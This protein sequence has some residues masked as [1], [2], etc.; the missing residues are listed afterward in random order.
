MRYLSATATREVPE[1]TEA[2]VTIGD[3]VT[4]TDPD[5][6]NTLTYTLEG[7]DLDSF[8]IDSASGQIQTKP[9]VTYDHETKSSYS[10]TVK[11]DEKNGGI[12]TIDVTITI[13]VTDVD[14]PLTVNGE[15]SV[16]YPENSD[17]QVATYSATDPD[18]G[19]ITWSL[20][21]DDAGGFSISNTGELTFQTAPDHEAPADDNTD[22]RY[23]LTVEASDESVK[24]ALDVTVT[25]TD[26]NEPPAFSVE[27]ASRTIAENTTTGVAIG[28]PVTATDPD[29]GDT[30]AYTLGGTDANF[31]DI[32]AS[33]GQL[34]TKAGLD[35]EV[36]NTYQIS[37]SVRDGKNAEGN[38]DAADDATITVTVTVT[39]VEEPGK[40]TLNLLQPQVGTGLTT[41]VTDPDGGVRGMT[42]EW[43]SSSDNKD[44]WTPTSGAVSGTFFPVDADVGNYLRVTVSYTDQRAQTKA[45]RQCRT[46]R[47]SQRRSTTN[48]RLSPKSRRTDPARISRHWLVL[49]VA[50][51]L[52][53]AYGTR[54]EDAHD[55]RITPGNLRTPPRAP[56]PRRRAPVAGTSGR[57]GGCPSLDERLIPLTVPE[58]RR[59]LYR[60]IW[61]HHPTDESVLRWSQWRRRHQATARRCHYRRRL[62]L[63]TTYLQ[64]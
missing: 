60:L 39:N 63:L 24:G 2:G 3:P 19:Q 16:G 22:N 48:R 27:T 34:R 15:T 18:N 56:T 55:R 11:A 38:P 40:V 12:A 20:S 61:R 47:Y 49:S 58:V 46:C 1:N 51:L 26:V 62:K 7:T 4:A 45:R 31:F 64:L 50:T 32:D 33:S 6:G 59:L 29:T 41:I 54:V 17:G 10:V 43:E 28:D 5:T 53:L 9:G 36:K 25:V 30:P 52:A 37:V 8:D 44:T 23:E 42:W 21:G 13:T 57:K 14:E 35:Y